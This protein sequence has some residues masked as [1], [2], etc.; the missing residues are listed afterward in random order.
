[1][2][3]Y[4]RR[5]VI[6]A[7]SIHAILVGAFLTVTWGLGLDF[8]SVGVSNVGRF[9]VVMVPVSL[10]AL[11]VLRLSTK[12]PGAELTALLVLGSVPLFVLSP[13]WLILA[14]WT[15]SDI[16]SGNG[17]RPDVSV[18]LGDGSRLVYF[19]TRDAGALG[20]AYCDPAHVRTVFPGLERRDWRSPEERRDSSG[21]PVSVVLHGRT[22]PLPNEGGLRREP[23]VEEANGP[24]TQA[25]P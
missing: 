15:L 2:Q 1:M 9:A 18:D 10:I 8:A 16:G 24:S 13:F 14:A 20:G 19:M 11:I 21:W 25:A 4:V 22:I 6:G 7:A 17:D 5:A 3:V 12:R 23:T